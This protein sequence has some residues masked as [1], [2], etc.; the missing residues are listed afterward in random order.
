MDEKMPSNLLFFS[1]V[2]DSHVPFKGP[3]GRL[4]Q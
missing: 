1:L 4:P 2:D 3:Q